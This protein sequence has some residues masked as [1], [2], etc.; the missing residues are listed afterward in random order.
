VIE[1]AHGF[2]T[3]TFVIDRKTGYITNAAK[4]ERAIYKHNERYKLVGQLQAPQNK[5]YSIISDDGKVWEVYRTLYSQAVLQ[6]TFEK[7]D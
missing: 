2:N 7:I 1:V 6:K 4:L 3:I 5:Y